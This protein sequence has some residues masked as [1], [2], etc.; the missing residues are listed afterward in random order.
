[1]ATTVPCTTA[2]KMSRPSA[3]ITNGIHLNSVNDSF[4]KVV[5]ADVVVQDVDLLLTSCPLLPPT[6]VY[7]ID[8]ETQAVGVLYGANIGSFQRGKK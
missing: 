5:H 6:S 1:M 8:V 3:P 2:R 7:R 4:T